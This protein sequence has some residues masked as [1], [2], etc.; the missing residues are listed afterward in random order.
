MSNE[1]VTW[2]FR[3]DLK[4][5]PKFVLVALADYAD[6]NHSCFPAHKKTAKRV[7]A[8]PSTVK[9]A[10][11]ELE[12]LGLIRSSG[13][14]GENGKRT[15]NRYVLNMSCLPVQSDPPGQSEP[16][17]RPQV[18]HTPGHSY[19]P[20]PRSQVTQQ[21]PSL[22]P[23]F[24]P[25]H[26][27]STPDG[28]AFD[29]WWK[30]YPKKKSKSDARTAFGSASKKISLDQ[31]VE[32]TQR[33]AR[34]MK[35]TDEKFIKHPAGWLRKQMWEDY[36]P[37]EGRLTSDPESLSR[38]DVDRILGPDTWSPPAPDSSVTNIRGWLAAQHREHRK[39]RLRQALERVNGK[40]ESGR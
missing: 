17:P 14:I 36:L 27:Q 21:E 31:L 2:A 15:T 10:L 40:S 3:Q 16:D 13:R 38:E 6:E 4:M 7:G 22:Y 11:S 20:Y 32:A 23:S 33:Y 26:E 19:D 39:E 35:G 24:E 28:D 25:S 5:T 37:V 29:R 12:K 1:A 34:D 9:R 8:S 30:E 18:P